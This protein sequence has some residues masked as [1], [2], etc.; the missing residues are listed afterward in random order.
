M[1]MTKLALALAAALA[2]SALTASAALAAEYK[3]GKSPVMLFGEQTKGKGT[4]T[5]STSTI[6]MCNANS[7]NS[8]RAR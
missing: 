3:S 5:C 6:R 2:M 4:N 8:K 7:R 1:K